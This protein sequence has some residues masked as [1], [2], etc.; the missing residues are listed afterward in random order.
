[1]RRLFE[2][3]LPCSGGKDSA[4]HPRLR[5]A[6][7]LSSVHYCRGAVG[8]RSRPPFGDNQRPLLTLQFKIPLSQA[9]S[10][11]NS[12]HSFDETTS[13]ARDAPR[14]VLSHVLFRGV[15]TPGLGMNESRAFFV[16][17]TNPPRSF[18]A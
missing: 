4:A 18:P 14:R 1:M 3:C 15:V 13:H 10:S 6:S 5:L 7:L 17:N 11:P 8:M 12:L 2:K 9:A 16:A